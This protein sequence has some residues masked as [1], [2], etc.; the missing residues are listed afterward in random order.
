VAGHLGCAAHEAPLAAAEVTRFG[1]LA[2]GVQGIMVDEGRLHETGG[3]TFWSAGELPARSVNLRT[4]SDDTYTILDAEEDG[5]VIGTVD[6]ISA[7]ELLFPEAIYLHDGATY[8]VRELDLEQ[9]VAFIEQRDV[10]YYTQP[11]L[12]N[13]IRIERELKNRRLGGVA[14]TPAGPGDSP[15]GA[16]A[17]AGGGARRADDAQAASPAIRAAGTRQPISERPAG[18][19]PVAG[20]AG[21]RLALGDAEVSWQTTAMRKV[22]FRSRDAIG[23]H[24]LD[25]PRLNLFTRSTWLWVGDDIWER[26]RGRGVNPMEPL[27]GLRNL[28]I[29]LV[30]MHVMSDPTDLGG[31]IDTGNT[32]R[33][34]IYLFDRY[35]GGLG[36]CDRAFVIF[37]ELVAACIELARDCPCRDGCPSCVGLP[38]LRPAQ[39]QDPD[40]GGGWPIPDKSA[41]ID[42]LESL[43]AAAGADEHRS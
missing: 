28:L 5:R 3:R 33:P 25:L 35:P 9:K 4:V 16:D 21:P 10:D 37:E 34:C 32:G 11:V 42:L 14:V 26:T 41:T 7:L 17:R 20:I 2:A 1:E 12:D 19:L 30:P 22:Q 43:Q 36:F 23:Y 15:P 18:A 31:V 8:Y 6:G 27:S 39:Q 13:W 29:T 24:A 40:M 38:I